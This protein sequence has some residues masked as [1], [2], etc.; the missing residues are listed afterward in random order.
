MSARPPLNPRNNPTST[1][2]GSN[3][4][5][6]NA[7]SSNNSN[8]TNNN[9]NSTNGNNGFTEYKLKMSPMAVSHNVMVL[10]STT[11][12]LSDFTQPVR[13]FRDKNSALIQEAPGKGAAG[14]STNEKIAVGGGM[15]NAPGSKPSFKKKT[16]VF[17]QGD[18]EEFDEQMR[19]A[20]TVPWLLEDYDAQHSF[21]GRLEGGQSS[22]YVFFV[23]QGDEFRIIPVNKWYRFQPKLSY[24]TLTLEEAETQMAARKKDEVSRWLMKNR[25]RKDDHQQRD[26]KD[27]LRDNDEE[28]SQGTLSAKPKSKLAKLAE[29]VL[30]DESELRS[31][32]TQMLKSRILDES[33][34]ASVE[35]LDFDELFDDDEGNDDFGGLLDDLQ[36]DEAAATKK[37]HKGVVKKSNYK[38][39]SEGRM[40]KKIVRQLDKSNDI[41]YASDDEND[42]YASDQEYFDDDDDDD[43]GRVGEEDNFDKWTKSNTSNIEPKKTTVNNNT[44]PS[45]ASSTHSQPSKSNPSSKASSLSNS[46]VASKAASPPA[47]PA[48]KSHS[49]SKRTKASSEEDQEAPDSN[50][51]TESEIIM[52]L[53]SGPLSTKD[54]IAK[55]KRQLKADPKNKEIFRELV[56]KLAMVK[57]SAGGSG[58]EDKLLELKPEFR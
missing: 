52:H 40:V 4:S 41:I 28:K 44:T 14:V 57:T 50:A 45:S 2:N 54:L 12:K 21:V 30:K 35:D 39:S 48:K 36:A 19:E 6:V 38:L 11:A 56:R 29:K 23:N 5:S 25:E 24:H 34:R 22:N 18:E 1:T 49:S 33:H 16:R 10:N 37:D 3:M 27:V 26:E 20:E 32:Q 47:S 13:M 17:F 9:N 15:I 43:D 58:E 8:N 55:F 31:R 53:K 51:I 46:P 7:N 42:P